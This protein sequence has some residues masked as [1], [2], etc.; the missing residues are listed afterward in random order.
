MALTLRERRLQTPSL[1][2][3]EGDHATGTY[4]DYRLRVEDLPVDYTLGST[5]TRGGG[6]ATLQEP[7]WATRWGLRHKGG[8]GDLPDLPENRE[9]KGEERSE[10]KDGLTWV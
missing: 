10:G 4:L 8:K 7:T 5:G 9:S 6:G 2:G 1:G 3:G